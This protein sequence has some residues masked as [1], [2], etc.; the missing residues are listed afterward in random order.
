MAK[1]KGFVCAEMTADG[2]RQF[3][4]DSE[5][6]FDAYVQLSD[7][8]S[9]EADHWGGFQFDLDPN[10]EDTYDADGDDLD[11]NDLE[12]CQV[13]TITE[14][15]DATADINEDEDEHDEEAYENAF[16]AVRDGTYRK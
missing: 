16:L 9:S 13:I 10:D 8:G 3:A 11:S 6:T 15:N 14:I 12:K 4:V 5:E 1:V 2:P 7:W